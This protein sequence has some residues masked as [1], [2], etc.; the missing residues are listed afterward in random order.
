[1]THL[2]SLIIIGTL[3][4]AEKQDTHIHRQSLEEHPPWAK[5]RRTF[6]DIHNY[7]GKLT[8]GEWQVLVYRAYKRRLSISVLLMIYNLCTKL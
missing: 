7:R 2:P 3:T 8:S 4:L 1:M 5:E 6:I